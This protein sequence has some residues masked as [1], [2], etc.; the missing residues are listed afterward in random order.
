MF[1]AIYDLED[2]IITICE[3]YKELANFFQKPKRSMESSVCRFT[4]GLIDKIRSNKDN[5]YYKVYK[6]KEKEV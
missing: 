5:S 2:N 4:K 1:Y 3:N 6:I